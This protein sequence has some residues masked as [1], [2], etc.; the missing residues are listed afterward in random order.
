ME[1]NVISIAI[2]HQSER[3]F[4]QALRDWPQLIDQA[5]GLGQTPLHLAVDWIYGVRELLQHGAS[6]DSDDL[7]GFSPVFHAIHMGYSETVRLLMKADCDLGSPGCNVL[8]YVSNFVD[9]ANKV[10]GVS[11]EARMNVLETVIASLAERRC[12]LQSR[13]AALP[14]VVN[15][16][17]SVFR[18][19]R[20]LDEYAKYAE[21]AEKN[22]LRGYGHIPRAST[23]LKDCRT[24]Y[25]LESL[26]VEVAERLWHNG[27]RDIDVQDNAG[28]TPLM[29]DRYGTSSEVKLLVWLIQKGA[30]LHQPQHSPLD[31]DPDRAL[32]PAQLL[33]KTRA[34]HYVAANIEYDQQLNQLSEDGKLFLGTVFS[35]VSCDDCVCAC[36]SSGCLASTMRLKRFTGHRASII[37]EK[38]HHDLI[39]KDTIKGECL[40]G[41]PSPRRLHSVSHIVYLITLVGPQNPCW[42]WLGKEIIR[43]CTF[44]E[45]ELRHTCCKWDLYRL[46]PFIKLG[47]EEC[48]EIRDE[49]HEKIELL[50]SLLD[51]FEENRGDQDVASFLDGYWATR[52]VQVRQELEDRVD[53]EGLRNIG[54]VLRR[55]NRRR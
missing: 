36:S 42:G 30:K 3:D 37:L 21:R 19:D 49:D 33:P 5:N 55:D 4:I 35:D 20:I 51:E 48:A 52:M 9:S 39:S 54:V 16:D 53:K 8:S 45:L 43:I 31:Y 10:W 41:L 14:S 17:T 46:G 28:L 12:D 50:A 15:I 34:L 47:P 40:E 32:D 13:L 22:A 11:Q 23:L 27:F 7:H 18:D 38:E 26:R 25:H 29:L 24:V 2:L 1:E 44:H 6:V